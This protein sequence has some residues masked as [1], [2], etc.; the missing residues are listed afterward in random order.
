MT[1]I[2][3]AR[4]RWIGVALVLLAASLAVRSQ[5]TGKVFQVGMV[6]NS[7]SM[8]ELAGSVPTPAGAR[9]F[10]DGLRD[11]GWV[12]GKNIKIHW[13]SAEERYERRPAL[14]EELARLPVDVLVVGGNYAVEEALQK[15]KTIPIVTVAVQAAVESK[16][17]ESLV[18]PGGN[19]TGLSQDPGGELQGKR[20]ALLKQIAPKVTRVALLNAWYS[21]PEANLPMTLDAAR[22]L[23]ISLFHQKIESIDGIEAAIDEAVR[24]GANGIFVTAAQPFSRKENQG[25]VHRAVERHRLPAIY[26]Y[27][28][29]SDSGGLVTYADD[30]IGRYRRAAY[31][32]DRILKGAK[33][34][35]IPIELP[36]RFELVVNLKAA[37]AIGLTIPASVLAQADRVIE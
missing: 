27:Q 3:I 14:I 19:L 21:R 31:Y 37:K 4:M 28:G 29:S 23:G 2:T 33:P 11:R 36:S 17:V 15:T 12:D 35:E 16:L 20:L 9:A 26:L 32:V 5:P 7:I 25:R 10:V 18:R 13:R 34:G 1:G 24:Q 22:E 30:P 8:A 6:F